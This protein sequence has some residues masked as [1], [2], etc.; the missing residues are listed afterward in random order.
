MQVA[1]LFG[2]AF[3][4]PAR[5]SEAPWSAVVDLAE[6]QLGRNGQLHWESAV[7][8][9]IGD[10]RLHLEFDGDG[11]ALSEISATQIQALFERDVLPGAAVWIGGEHDDGESSMNAA[12]LGACL[13]ASDSLY[14]ETSLFLDSHGRIFH[15]LKII[16]MHGVGSH[17]YLEPR[18]VLDSS[19]QDD[20]S[21]SIRAG[22]SALS[23]ALRLRVKQAHGLAPYI[24]VKCAMAVGHTATWIKTHG[25]E[26]RSCGFV[27][28][29]GAKI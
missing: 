4:A 13:Q 1:A 7:Y 6:M 14:G 22:P 25:G 12:V 8:R 20:P 21:G 15:Q 18:L 16:A 29:L 27:L 11:Q 10:G 5:A 19:L 28:G 17:L 26:V 23:L 2:M 3:S 24:G 9:S